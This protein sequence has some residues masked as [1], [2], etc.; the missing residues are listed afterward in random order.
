M[1]KINFN[2][3]WNFAFGENKGAEQP[4]NKEILYTEVGLPHTFNLPYFGEKDFYIGYGTYSKHFDF[5]KNIKD[6]DILLHFG[7][8]FQHID[9]FVNGAF[10]GSHTGGYTAFVIDITNFLTIGDNFIF[11]RV[12]NFWKSD[13]SPRAGEHTFCGGIYRDLEILIAEKSRLEWCGDFIKTINT[14]ATSTDIVIEYSLKNAV[15]KTLNT[16]IYDENN[17]ELATSQIKIDGNKV[18]II[19]HLEDI[20]LWSPSTPYLYTAKTTI[21]NDVTTTSFGIRFFEFTSD[22]GFFLNGSHF[23]IEG[24]NA[25]QDR[26]GWGDAG[27]HSAIKRDIEMIKKAGFNLIRGS[28][29]PHHTVFSDECD[30]QGMLLWSE[31]TFWGIGGFV[32]EGYWNCS[33]Y[34]TD[35]DSEEAFAN[36]CKQ[37]MAEMI[38]THR[39]HPSIITWSIG[40]EIFFIPKKLL[41]KAKNLILELKELAHNMDDSRPISVGGV[42]RGDLHTLGDIAGFNGDGAVL[43]KNP[44]VPNIVAEYGSVIDNRPGKYRLHYTDGTEKPFPWRSGRVLWCAFHHGSIANIG[45]MGIIDLYRLPLRAYYAYREKLIGIPPIKFPIKGIATHLTMEVDKKEISCDGTQDSRILVKLLDKNNV[46]VNSVANIVLK[47]KSGGGY[48]PSGSE[49]KMSSN[50]GTFL[51]GTGAIE[52]RSYYSGEIKVE[53]FAEGLKPCEVI[54]NAIGEVKYDGREIRI[55]NIP[56]YEKHLNSAEV[57]LILDRPISVSSENPQHPRNFA[58]DGNSNTYYQPLEGVEQ[59]IKIDMENMYILKK[60]TI[61]LLEQ[62]KCNIKIEVS[63]DNIAFHTIYKTIFNKKIK[64]K[65]VKF[66]KRTEGRYLKITFRQCDNLKINSISV[67]E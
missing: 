65:T 28:H 18:N 55:P 46:H 58:T 36:H 35:V 37:T 11:L 14:T 30:K 13:V 27:T 4:L 21:G 39:N 48:F 41:P 3:F 15:G 29:Y 8:V 34:P 10:C 24:V 2:A 63:K 51:D 7:G 56:T 23:L 52:L 47:I 61:I 12:N 43:F 50:N 31:S 20:N 59:T 5:N 62:T 16:I 40:N 64:D 17:L 22:Q 32:K 44:K 67:F 26:G 19:I 54:I 60:F 66:K 42:Q 25:H 53:A 9:V 6:K 33:A 45:N 1:E 57:D 38:L 49:W